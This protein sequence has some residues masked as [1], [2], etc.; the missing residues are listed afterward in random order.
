LPVAVIVKMDIGFAMSSA[1]SRRKSCIIFRH[2]RHAVLAE[3]A[4]D[5]RLLRGRQHHVE[6]PGVGHL[7]LDVLVGR[8]GRREVGDVRQAVAEAR[9]LDEVLRIARRVSPVR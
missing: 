3:G 2:A 4:G 1:R 5:H 6:A 8:E 9:V 7:R